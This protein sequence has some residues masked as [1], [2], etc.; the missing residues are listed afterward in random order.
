MT[1]TPLW[2]LPFAGLLLS[3]AVGPLIAPHFWRRHFGKIT[4]FWALAFLL[5]CAAVFGIGAAGH[6]LAHALLTEYL[7]FILLLTALYTTA[8][9]IY[10]GGN[11]HGSPP[12]NCGLLLAGALLASVMGTT[13]ASM[14]LIRPLIRANDHRKRVTHIVVFFIFIVSN[15]GGALTPLG[16]PPLF[17]GFLLGVPFFWTLQHLALPTTLLIAALLAIFYVVDRHYY[18][19]EGMTRPAPDASTASAFG[20]DG[21][22]NFG[23]I[24]VVLALV[25]VSGMWRSDAGLRVAGIMLGLPGLVRDAGLV[26]VALLSLLLTPRAVREKNQFGWAPMREVAQLFAGIF[27]T[28]IPVAAML[29]TGA[30]GPFGGV[31][32]AATGTD[33]APIPALYFWITGVLS[34][35]LDN[36]PTYL[37]F[38]DA[39]GGNAS[40][41]ITAFPAT[42][43]A[44]SAGAVFMGANTYIGNAPNLMVKAIAQER[45]IAMPSFLGYMVWSGAIL[46]PLFAA[47]TGIFF[48]G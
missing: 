13:G 8:G 27:L 23:L 1:F 18:R 4:A 20:F 7:P 15:I 16:D 22:L 5:P 38:F 36:A 44:I 33:G 35:F 42:L 41:L 10:I 30:A 11:L 17:L 25:L 24:A 2:S 6:A 40:H 12:L 28:I 14:L 47:L 19:Q 9:G 26:A 39:V 43:A 34:S 32:Q 29:Q 45:G 48:W 37:V 46:I 3:I 21:A 31:I